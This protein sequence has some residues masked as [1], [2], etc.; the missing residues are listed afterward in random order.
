MNQDVDLFIAEVNRLIQASGGN[1]KNVYVG[2]TDDLARRFNE[3][4]LREADQTA[5]LDAK[6]LKAAKLIEDYFVN[7]VGTGGGPGGENENTHFVYA[8]IGQLHTDP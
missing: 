5:T 8:Y 2:I 1:P 3:H 7:R 4:K 6:S